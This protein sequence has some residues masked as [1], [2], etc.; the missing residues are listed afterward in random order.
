MISIKV[1]IKSPK[2]EKDQTSEWGYMGKKSQE[3]TMDIEMLMKLMVKRNNI[4]IHECLIGEKYRPYADVD[5][6][7]KEGI[8][9]ENFQA[10]RY[11][12]L[13]NAFD[14]M[15]KTFPDAYFYLF[16]R[17]GQSVGSLHRQQHLLQ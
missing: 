1:D 16:D 12:I 10:R 4:G 17:S 9:E 15:N 7:K 8:T 11:E 5:A 2:D 3:E 13:K 6:G 14:V